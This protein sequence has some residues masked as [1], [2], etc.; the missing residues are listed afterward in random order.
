MLSLN[1]YTMKLKYI[2]E[3][4]A[5]FIFLYQSSFSLWP[6]PSLLSI[7]TFKVPFD[8]VCIWP[9]VVLVALSC[10]RIA[11]CTSWM[12]L[13][14]HQP[15]SGFFFSPVFPS[16]LPTFV[17]Q[18]HSPTPCFMGKVLTVKTILIIKIKHKKKSNNKSHLL[19]QGPA[20]CRG[21]LYFPDYCFG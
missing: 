4:V 18:L 11:G 9:V 8:V 13:D 2:Y 21:N 15:I 17:S 19:S 3:Y 6:P 14:F 1:N 16:I 12:L 7:I 10:P 5:D 20:T